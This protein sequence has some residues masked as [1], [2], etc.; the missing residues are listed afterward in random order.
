M[1]IQNPLIIF[2]LI[3]V[4]NVINIH[5]FFSPGV[6]LGWNIGKKIEFRPG[7]E[8]SLYFGIPFSE[9]FPNDDTY[10]LVGLVY[11]I[12]PGSKYSTGGGLKGRLSYLEGQAGFVKFT[13]KL[14][15]TEKLSDSPVIGGIALGKNYSSLYKGLTSSQKNRKRMRLFLGNG[16]V[17]LSGK[18]P[19][20]D[21]DTEFDIVV[22]F[23]VG[24]AYWY[25]KEWGQKEESSS[26]D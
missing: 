8:F 12:Q 21:N 1:R 18:M 20:F 10:F 9:K 17:F 6:K 5:G 19:V 3:L 7:L 23:P 13:G 24:L 25:G 14:K 11:G 4:M 2:S 22:K 26:Q 16:I 15:V